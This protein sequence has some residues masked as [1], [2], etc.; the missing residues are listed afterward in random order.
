VKVV[1]AGSSGLIGSALRTRLADDGHTVVRLVRRAPTAADEMRW[2]PAAGKLD[3]AALDG[4]DAVV[5][6]AGAGIGDKRWSDD[7]KRKLS[8]SR[9]DSTR[10]LAGA[11]TQVG[12]PTLINASAMGYYGSRGDELLDEGAAPGSD[13]LAELCTRW[14][15][16][17]AEADARVVLLRTGLVLSATEGALGRQLRL[18]KL[19]V[20]GRIG[21]GRQWQSW[22]TLDDDVRAIVHLL[23]ADVEG[24]VNICTPAPVRNSEFATSL[25]RAVHRP[26]VLP[27]PSFA[28]KVILGG[29][30][31][32]GLLLASQRMVPEVLSSSGF[33]WTEP[34][35]GGALS[36][37][38]L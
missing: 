26:A 13:F 3:L 1:V 38:H 33:A 25:G 29:E 30:L 28:P 5:N 2:D 22:I 35:L 31:V 4:A 21:S 6:L 23:G 24:P 11:V 10:L 37:L 7:Y 12:V 14:E 20:G 19:G 32:E 9:L 17:A 15:A 34:E 36:S 18:F 27:I 16:A 8:S